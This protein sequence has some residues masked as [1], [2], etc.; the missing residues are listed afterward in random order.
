MTLKN[1]IKRRLRGF[2]RNGKRVELSQTD[3]LGR[4][5]PVVVLGDAGMGKTTLLEE[6]GA[7]KGHKY[8]HARRLLR[9]QNAK[10]L[11]EGATTLVID[12]LDELTVQNDGDAVDKVLEKLENGGSPNFILAC[13]VADW[14]SATSIQAMSDSYGVEP[15][16]LFLE[17]ISR[18]EAHSILSQ[19][20]GLEKA[21]NVIKHFERNSLEELFGNPQTLK[22]IEAV[23]REEELPTSRTALFELSTKKIW[24]EHSRKKIGS[25][26]SHIRE[27]QAL[28]VAGS[29]FASL[30]LAGKRAVSRS[31]A[32]D[33]EEDDLPL[34]EISVFSKN[35]DL[36]A[37]LESRLLTSNVEG[38]PDR[39]SY[40]HRSVGEFLA[41][42]WLAAEANTDRKRR[43][44]LKLFHGQGLVPASLRG[45]HAWLA[46]DSRLALEV[47]ETDP[48]GVVEYG[49]TDD[50]S[51]DQ[52]RALLKS[53][54]ELG[55]RD[56]RYFD[57]EKTHSMPG[58]AKPSL[59]QDIQNLIIS[60]ATPFSLRAIL[61]HSISGSPVAALLSQTLTEMVIDPEVTFYE[62][63]VAG[64]ALPDLALNNDEW[65]Q[66]FSK[67]HD[68]ADEDSLRLA[69]ELLPGVEFLGISDQQL[70]ELIVAFCGF[71]ICEYPQKK[72]TRIGGVLWGLEMKLPVERIEPVLDTLADYLTALLPDNQ[73]RHEDSDAINLV[74]TLTERRLALGKIEPLK[75]WHWLSCFGERRGFRKEAQKTISDWL[76]DNDDVRREIQ[77]FALLEEVGPRTVWM[78]G[79]RLRD[80][81]TGLYPSEADIIALLGSLDPTTEASEDRWKDLVRLCPHDGERGKSVRNAAVVF[82]TDPEGRQFLERLANPETPE[83]QIEQDERDRKH[84]EETQDR[85]AEHRT[86]FLEQID[87][88]RAGKYR[89][90]VNPAQAYLNLFTDMGNDVPA[91]ERV[92]QWLGTELQEAAFQGFEAYLTDEN[93]KPTAKEIAVSYAESKRWA[94]AYIFVAAAAERVRNGKSFDDLS[95]E[96]LLAV[97]LE[98]RFTH[99]LDHAG[100][101][102][103]A[104]KVEQEVRKRSGM[105]EGYWRL[106][107]EPQLAAGKDH[108]DGLYEIARSAD[109][110]QLAVPLAMEWLERYPNISHQAEI[111]LVDCLIAARK[112]EFLKRLANDRRK[113]EPADEQRCRD[114]DAVAFLVDFENVQEQLKGTYESE[115]QFLWNL[116]ARLGRRNDE[117]S[118]TLLSAEQLS[119][120]VRNFRTIWPAVPHPRGGTTGDVNP[121]DATEFLTALINR[122]GGLTSPEAKKELSA[123]SDATC[124]SY[125]D[126]LKRAFAE[127]AQKVV[128]ENYTPFTISELA[129]VLTDGPPSSA[130][131]LQAVMLEELIVAQSKIRSHPADWYRDF[132][133]NG[134]PKDEEAC[135]DTLLKMFGDYPNGILC[136]PEGHL[137][138]DKRVDIKC[139]ISQLMLPIEIKGQWRNE[140]WTAADAQLDR[141]YS[142]D[143]RTGRKGIY[144]VIWFGTDVPKQKKLRSPKKGANLPTS[145]DEL[146]LALIENSDIAK[147]GSIEIFVLDLARP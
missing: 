63:R 142:S 65:V 100:I 21:E 85:W 6:I 127:Q 4:G 52:A 107:I 33:L 92:E 120:I 133:E 135:R 64:N 122:L 143:W 51:D 31:T 11:L 90:V 57:F 141:L 140:L 56:P 54:L 30:I 13:R 97:L 89:E 99:I 43:R 20:V 114:W 70:V 110:A 42:R 34:A 67:L 29:T 86:N 128:E 96:R 113:P 15:L 98:I 119:W 129:S 115:P 111:E 24:A 105:W 131:Q 60:R 45:V 37:I 121:W 83:W 73:D 138:D 112:F 22:L 109:H 7:T 62:R 40:S 25:P 27:E 147:T 95:N 14:R 145:A 132:F 75:L 39:F 71:S 61:L 50:L 69:L 139:T 77:H 59:R 79:W 47:I 87:D 49:D 35:E 126:H 123:L 136:E 44:L 18:D 48:M 101:D 16:E 8:V 32:F 5:E 17:P 12:A 19:S 1:K 102:E 80:S 36:H 118:P 91:H 81:L 106:R 41:A 28:D 94:A 117:S 3:L 124:D 137:A 2:D 76:V 38:N 78:R 134:V 46:N 93:S 82:A 9:T 55:N 84:R 125:T 74:Y 144:L 146:R 66:I 53:L 130:E 104:E 58:I 116:R 23:A 72:T 88:L 10:F 26:L 68:L 103:V 108:V